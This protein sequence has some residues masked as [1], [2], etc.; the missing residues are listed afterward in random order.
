[1]EG[2]LLTG[3]RTTHGV[4]RV[5]DTVRRPVLR[6]PAFARD[7]LL[8][9]ERVG[10]CGAPRFLGE[11]DAGREILSFLPGSVP[12]DLGDYT[13]AQ[14]GMAAA[15]LRRFHDSTATMPS[16][17]LGGFEVACHNDWAP[18][19]TVFSGGEPVAMIDFD[20]AAPGER[21]WDLGYSAF[22][23]LDL[24]NEELAGEEQIRRLGV[25]AQGYGLADCTVSRI[26]VYAVARQAGLAASTRACGKS[27][28]ADWASH[29]ADWTSLNVVERLLPTG[30]RTGKSD[31]RS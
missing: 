23:W 7:C 3:G 16:V 18:T 28:V 11:D 14:L 10:F 2:E 24:G 13:D 4:V 1:M 29:C 17:R 9:L 5:G 8:H 15:L 25:F 30:Y 31:G 6:D 20:T 27:Q 21:L 19:N 26:A 22:T 12:S